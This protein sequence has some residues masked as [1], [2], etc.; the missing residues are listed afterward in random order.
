MPS[1]ASPLR[2]GGWRKGAAASAAGAAGV[3]LPASL[4]GVGV[5]VGAD[6]P[7]DLGLGVAGAALP[8]RAEAALAALKAE[9]DALVAREAWLLPPA[10]EA[11]VRSQLM[12]LIPFPA[13]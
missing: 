10:A 13:K 2:A 11:G 12:G 5:G 8:P 4:R 1:S 7:R 9:A 6:A 3:G